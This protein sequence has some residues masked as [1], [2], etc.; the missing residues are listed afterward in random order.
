MTSS[1]PRACDF[2]SHKAWTRVC[3]W[4]LT[5]WTFMLLRGNAPKKLSENT[6]WEEPNL[7]EC[8]VKCRH[9]AGLRVAEA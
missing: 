5:M 2:R 6:R 9:R 8:E 3:T 1:I 4:N 7:R